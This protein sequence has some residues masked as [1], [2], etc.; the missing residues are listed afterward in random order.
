MLNGRANCRDLITFETRKG[1]R[2]G[3][4]SYSA[5]KYK[6]NMAEISI[7]TGASSGIGKALAV[8]Y[9]SP[10]EHLILAARNTGNLSET[11]RLCENK[12]AETS[13]FPLDL[14]QPGSVN[15]F[16]EEV[17][18][19]TGRIGRL[20]HVGGISQ[21]S[22]AVDTNMDVDRRI[23]E[24]NYF[25]AVHLTKLL[26]PLLIAHGSARIAVTSSI[27]G[28]F[29]FYE[30][31]AYSASKF[32]LHGFFES[33]RL[34]HEKDGISVS[35]LCPGSINTDISRHALNAEGKAHG[36]SDE[37]LSSGMPADVCARKMKRAVEK[38]KKETLIGGRE[39][40]MVHLKKYLPGIFYKTARK[41]K[42]M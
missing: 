31:S 41:F 35:I 25:G 4:K 24:V 15:W 40:L 13:V 1:P 39:L 9:A 21:R 11:A 27:S 23:M 38:R 29:G 3:Y 14:S 36:K 37:R 16:A 2:V 34:E 10:G 6:I 28:K 30:R 19:Q 22:F 20:L 18:H 32:A 42:S 5:M 26:L 33:L 7:I 8:A 17:K 12:G